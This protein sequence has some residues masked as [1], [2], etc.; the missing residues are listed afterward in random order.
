MCL[1]FLEI[2]GWGFG[3]PSG[4]STTAHMGKKTCECIIHC[5]THVRA[6][7]FEDWCWSR[8]REMQSTSKQQIY[9]PRWCVF[10]ISHVGWY[11]HFDRH[12]LI[13]RGCEINSW[14]WVM[15]LHSS[16]NPTN[17]RDSWGSNEGKRHDIRPIFGSKNQEN[18]EITNK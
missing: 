2:L 8:A 12:R 18:R 3:S 15:G 4:G 6:D 5:C 11:V 14:L 17:R 9:L 1:R 10:S 13:R 7:I 16:G